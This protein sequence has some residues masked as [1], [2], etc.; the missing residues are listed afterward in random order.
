M[1]LPIRF[2]QFQKFV[3]LQVPGSFIAEVV[4]NMTLETFLVLII[5]L[6]GTLSPDIC[7]PEVVGDLILHKLGYDRQCFSK[8]ANWELDQHVDCFLRAIS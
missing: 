5:E 8:R 7:C 6:K 1:D 4:G 3:R 2:S